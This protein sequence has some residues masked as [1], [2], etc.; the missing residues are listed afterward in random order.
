MILEKLRDF[1]WLNEPENVIFA[2]KE[3]KIVA[4]QQTDFWQSKHHNFSKD[5]GH[6]F[7]VNTTDDFKIVI[8]WKAIE[9]NSFKQCGLMIRIDDKN[10][11]KASLM[12][13][14]NDSPEIGSCLTVDGHSDWAGVILDEEPFQ[15]WYK[16]VRK[17]NDFIAYYSL[18]G[19]KYIR[20]RQFYM[21]S[22]DAQ[23]RVGA[24]IC[25]P[26]T[27]KFEAVLEDIDFA[28]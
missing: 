7:F 14:T 12:Y 5:D 13:Q 19:Q 4:K 16:L 15:L 11:F 10:W 17:D 24:Y 28:I 2:D 18:D 8:Q 3:M 6:L 21:P 27:E 9:V 1:E 25:S 22:S 20:L 26:Q 23:I